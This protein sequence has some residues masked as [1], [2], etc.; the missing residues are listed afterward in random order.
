MVYD[1][2]LSNQA[3]KNIDEIA[4][5]LAEY[6]SEDIKLNFLV[7][8][9]E[10]ILLLEKMPFIYRKSISKPSVRECVVNKYVLMY[11]TVD[12]ETSVVTVLALKNLRQVI[13]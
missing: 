2:R 9:T 1:V 7:N 13:D 5:S 12:V 6:Y 3:V 10:K 11:Y 4:V 8:V